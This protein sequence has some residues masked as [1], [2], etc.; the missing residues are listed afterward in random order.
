MMNQT[1]H[2]F[3]YAA[4]SIGYPFLLL[5]LMWVIYWME[6]S[7]DLPLVTFGVKPHDWSHWYGLIF[8]PLI[9]DNNDIGHILNNS[10]PVF[11]LL[12]ALVF[13][14]R[15]VAFQV[16]GLVWL[17]SGLI[18]WLFAAPMGGYHIGMSGVI[19]GLFGFL[20]ISG[21]LRHYRPLQV[22]SLGVALFYGSMI[23]G[24]FPQ[25]TKVSWE[26]HFGGFLS[27]VFLAIH[28]RKLGPIRPKYQ[29]EIEKELGIEPPD[30]EGMWNE[31]QALALEKQLAELEQKQQQAL[32]IVYHYK[33][34]ADAMP[35][36]TP[37]DEN[38]QQ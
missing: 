15:D 33:T 24:I 13:Y 12:A 23:W 26:G 16:F 6:I 9:H 10:L 8:M 5:I 30:F 1:K 4:E 37:P 32:H 20:F 28:Y 29:Y 19:Y 36:V 3:G 22:I 2:S 11:V 27:G 31:Q 38:E 18:V 17:M 14:Y 7:T 35:K 21:F 34:Q 25:E